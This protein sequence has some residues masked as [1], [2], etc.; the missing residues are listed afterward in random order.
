MTNNRSERRDQVIDRR[1]ELN[2][3]K[4]EIISIFS[5]SILLAFLIG[6]EVYIFRSGQNL[7]SSYVLFLLG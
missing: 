4:R 6:V 2:K 7:P 5:I 1:Q 3:R